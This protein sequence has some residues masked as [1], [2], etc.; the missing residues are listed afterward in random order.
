MTAPL[1][2]R[3]R[4]LLI[5]AAALVVLPFAMSALG[6]TISTA[7]VV[8][9]L[10]IAVLGL[11]MMMG[12]TGLIS[13]GHGAW[14]GIGAYAAAIAQRNWF[15]GQIFV[16]ILFAVAFV[17]LLSLV[18]GALM[19]RRRGVY[20]ALMTL[21]LSALV[22][23][24]SFRWTEVTGGEDGLGGLTRGTL[25]P[26]DLGN[27]VAWYA[28][29]AVIGLA[30]LY[31]LIRV[32]RSPF[33]H[34]LVAIRE[35]QMRA[36]FQGYP[37]QRYKLAVF[38][39]SSSITALA[40]ALSAFQHYIVTAEATSVDMSGELLAMVVI[41]G[42]HNILGPAVGVL[43]YIVFRELFSIWTG[44]WLFWFG[45]VFVAF[46]MYSP[47]GIVGVWGL[48]KKRFN[49]PAEDGAAMSRRKIYEGLPL[50]EFLRPKAATNPVLEISGISKRFGGIRAVEDASLTVKAGQIHALIGPNGAG[51]TTLFNL[52]SGRFAP[53]KGTVRLRGKEIQGIGA[54]R[55]CEQGLARSF[56]ITNLFEGLSIYEN[57]RLSAQAQHPGR[58]NMW[59]DVD[60]YAEV[61]GDTRELVK[62]LGLEGI[63]TARGGD[64]SYGGQR[65]VDLGIALASRPQVLL[66]DE[67]L[68]GLAAAERERVSRLVVRVAENIPVLIVEHD[69]DRILGF[70]HEVT[71]MNE[72]RVLVTG[73]PEAIRC[74]ER[75]QEIYTGKGT[76]D[77]VGRAAPSSIPAKTVLKVDKVNTL[78][79][80]PYPQRCGAGDPAARDRCP[81]WPQRRRQ[82]DLPQVDRRAGAGPQRQHRVR[83]P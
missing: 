81:A 80:E 73:N 41:G 83:R 25:G 79:Q 34:T 12:Y 24:I 53:D 77:V 26:I 66:L 64:L 42:M 11:N 61:N 43:F 16:P 17:A 23:T 30:V 40:G 47:G 67:P 74:N 10:T 37:V 45:L 78:R 22:Y 6:L 39:L 58:F 70:S 72:G 71:V 75:V 48:V 62:F 38:V 68:A 46:V 57:L 60:S 18:V 44:D 7:T 56:Q 8:V 36:S 76:P 9:F 4:P 55:I 28:F 50:P 33:G 1:L 65:L 5:G 52:V 31:A 63:E 82:V 2:T 19:L 13:F 69:I 32:T 14:F 49:P 15:G 21:A 27:A 35:N 54:D 51:K 59:R 29:V 20:F 3:Y